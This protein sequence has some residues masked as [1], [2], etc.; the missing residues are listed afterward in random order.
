MKILVVGSGGR[1]HALV[2]T[3]ARGRGISRL[4]CA[5]G[6]A[7]IHRDAEP[8]PIA[9][10]DVE[11]LGRV[12]VALHKDGSAVVGWVESST[13]ASK[14]EIRRIQ[15]NGTRSPAAVVGNLSG[16][17]YPRLALAR[18]EVVLAWTESENESSRVKT[19]R[20]RLP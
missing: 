13:Q 5:P 15:P 9:A 17:R 20:A 8:I 16:T 3:L 10:D 19:A 12:G 11:S 6:N 4:A 14:F 18:D 1:E 2:R 7:G